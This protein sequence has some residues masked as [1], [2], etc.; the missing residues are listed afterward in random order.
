M[1]PEEEA[2]KEVLRRLYLKE[3]KTQEEKEFP[4]GFEEAL[5]WLCNSYDTAAGYYPESSYEGKALLEH[6]YKITG[7]GK[8]YR[9]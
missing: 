5:T 7:R 4:K 2:G 6:Y 9:K 8:D 1:T 3:E